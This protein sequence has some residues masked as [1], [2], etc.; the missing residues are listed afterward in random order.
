[1]NVGM[2]EGNS[3]TT[4]SK[5]VNPILQKIFILNLYGN[6]CLQSSKTKIHF[7]LEILSSSELDMYKELSLVYFF[8]N[9]NQNT[10]G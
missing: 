2:G 6:W 3:N 8:K 7:K 9:S 10:N 1:M 4:L 5:R